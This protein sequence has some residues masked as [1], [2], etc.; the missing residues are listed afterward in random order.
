MDKL[1]E[2]PSVYRQSRDYARE[3]GEIPQFRD[4]FRLNIACKKDI[5]TAVRNNFDGMHLSDDAVKPVLEHY[6]AERVAY[7]LANT[8]QEKSWDGRFSHSNKAWAETIPIAEN[9]AFGENRNFEFAVDSHPAILD[10]FVTMFRD[11]MRERTEKRESVLGQLDAMKKA[12]PAH[13]GKAAK[14]HEECR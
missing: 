12:A 7:V 3:H 14:Q 6:G 13:T 11:E 8:I 9:T 10:G 2:F 1:K 4:S 5:E